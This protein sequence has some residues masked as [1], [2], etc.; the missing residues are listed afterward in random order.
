MELA[1]HP[2]AQAVRFVDY[3]RDNLA[4]DD[5]FDSIDNTEIL[6]EYEKLLH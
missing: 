6:R 2:T 5:E 1:D 3:V 4:A